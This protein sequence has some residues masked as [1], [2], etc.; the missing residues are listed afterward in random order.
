MVCLGFEP[1]AAGWKAQTN[2]L[3]Y[4]GTPGIFIVPIF[5]CSMH[6]ILFSNSKDSVKRVGCHSSQQKY[7]T[8]NPAIWSHWQWGLRDYSKRGF[9]EH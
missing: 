4:G 1:G 7:L 8:K 5:T 6:S 2:P 3:S 9:H